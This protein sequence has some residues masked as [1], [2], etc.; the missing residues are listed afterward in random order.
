ML[1]SRIRRNADLLGC[2][3]SDRDSAVTFD[4]ECVID[5][6]VLPEQPATLFAQGRQFR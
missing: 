5:G 3:V 4:I 2:A 6:W 1:R